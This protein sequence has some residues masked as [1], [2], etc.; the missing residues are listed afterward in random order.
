M[1]LP[2]IN[3]KIEQLYTSF[4]STARETS[5]MYARASRGASRDIFDQ[6]IDGKR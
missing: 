5:D 1:S 4:P 6:L 2:E 3:H